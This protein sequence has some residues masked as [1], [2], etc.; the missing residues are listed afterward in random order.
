MTIINT[1][2][3]TAAH[4][5]R[6]QRF[7]W[8]C[9]GANISLLEECRSEWHKFTA[10]GVFVILV[11][12]LASVSGTFFLTESLG[13][14]LYLAVF[15]GLFWGV[16]ILSVD[17][18][19]LT[20]FH[21]GNGEWKRAIPRIL[22]S[23]FISLVINDPLLLKFFSGEIEA[24]LRDVKSVKLQSVRAGSD[25]QARKDQLIS[26]IKPLQERLEKLQQI[27]DEAEQEKEKE[28]GGIKS[29]NT[30][31]KSGEGSIY[32]I[33]SQI[34]EAAK[35]NYESEKPGLESQISA[36]TAELQRIED[37]INKEV[38]STD[39]IESRASGV[40]NRQKALWAIL[41][42]SPETAFIYVPL[43]CLLLGIETLPITQKLGSRKGKY[44]F[45]MDK[46]IEFAEEEAGIIFA[47]RKQSILRE[48]DSEEAVAKRI[49]DSIIDGTLN[50]SNPAEQELAKRVHL[51]ILRRQASELYGNNA[52]SNRPLSLGK[53]VIIEAVGY[54]Q[55]SAQ[56][57]IPSEL[58]DSVTL[59]DLASEVESFAAEV[60]KESKTRV[61]LA[62]ATN[63]EAEEIEQTFLPLIHQLKA[64][65][66][67]L[68]YFEPQ[69]TASDTFIRT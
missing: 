19:L 53:P 37:E 9:A 14:P 61:G 30:T 34:F 54:P 38:G 24:K 65:R 44:D 29:A 42:E 48:R 2:N 63:S 27:K 20:F 51:E 59:N 6:V 23:V 69:G 56:M 39:E 45:L 22:L 67:L 35:A 57:S 49:S 25:K 8:W 55:L 15:G 3:Q 46:E 5:T 50:P 18:L 32:K 64:D 36:K 58:E 26:E 13:V 7:F 1:T 43:F 33:K 47:R 28:R 10:I 4:T 66:R 68:L 31:G 16:L 60:S 11:G 12:L 62:R 52:D 41:R 21:K 17:R 40:L